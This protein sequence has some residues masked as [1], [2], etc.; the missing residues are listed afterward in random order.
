[1]RGGRSKYKTS[2]KGT[3]RVSEMVRFHHFH[4][5]ITQKLKS[6]TMSQKTTGVEVSKGNASK[7]AKSK[8]AKHSP[9]DRPAVAPEKAAAYIEKMKAK[10]DADSKEFAKNGKI[11]DP[12]I[13]EKKATDAVAKLVNETKNAKPSK[14]PTTKEIEPKSNGPKGFNDESL[15]VRQIKASEIVV[16]FESFL[17]KRSIGKTEVSKYVVVKLVKGYAWPV[18]HKPLKQ[19]FPLK[20]HVPDYEVNEKTNVCISRSPSDVL[21]LLRNC[22]C[23]DDKIANAI[24][25]PTLNGKVKVEKPIKSTPTAKTPTTSK[26][27][28]TDKPKGDPEVFVPLKSF[29]EYGINCNR[30]MKNLKTHVLIPPIGGAYRIGRVMIPVAALDK[31]QF[32]KD[33]GLESVLTK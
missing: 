31:P 24:R 6:L 12:V 28:T 1:M 13:D 8:K 11:A 20:K 10:V 9:S 29:P 32:V 5:A 27:K 3:A 33:N 30:T 16:S 21:H 22:T 2:G 23:S 4:N 19:G 25:I 15:A 26:P 14:T 18:D 17:K 7:V